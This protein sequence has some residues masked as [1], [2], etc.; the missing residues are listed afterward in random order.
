MT[1]YIKFFMPKLTRILIRIRTNFAPHSGKNVVIWLYGILF[2]VNISR[3]LSDIRFN[4]GTSPLIE[5]PRNLVII[6]VMFIEYVLY[7]RLYRDV[8]GRYCWSWKPLYLIRISVYMY[9]FAYPIRSCILKILYKFFTHLKRTITCI[10]Y[11]RSLN[12]YILFRKVLDSSN[13]K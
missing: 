8:F 10:Q 1:Y 3:N 2:C 13:S 6:F 11:S 9:V 4:H 12:K 5:K 7:N